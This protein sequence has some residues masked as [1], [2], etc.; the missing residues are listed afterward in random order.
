MM[1][2]SHQDSEAVEY[3]NVEDGDYIE[4]LWTSGSY[5]SECSFGIY[6]ATGQ[7]FSHGFRDSRDF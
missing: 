6:D 4:T 3:F 5:D 1:Q 7:C 2:P